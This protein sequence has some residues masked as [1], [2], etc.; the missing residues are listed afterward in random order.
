MSRKQWDLVTRKKLTL[1]CA[2]HYQRPPSKREKSQI[3]D[4]FTKL[5]GYNRSYASWLLRHAGRRV[6]IHTPRVILVA[7]PH[8]KIKCKRPKTYDHEVLKSLR[9]IWAILDC[10]CS[11]KLKA[12]FPR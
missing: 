3:L 1:A 4:E 6:T 5:T 10:P 11:L 8:R 2:K 12:S 9:K 7:D